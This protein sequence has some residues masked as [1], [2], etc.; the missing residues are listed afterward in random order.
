MFLPF[1]FPFNGSHQFVKNWLKINKCLFNERG[2]E[3]VKKS[4]GHKRK[5][6]E[7]ITLREQI[8]LN[9]FFCHPQNYLI[10]LNC[11]YWFDLWLGLN[12]HFFLA[13]LAS[14][15]GILVKAT[16]GR[17]KSFFLAKIN[18]VQRA[19]VKEQSF[20]LLLSVFKETSQPF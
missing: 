2:E 4:K 8:K 15:L 11:T 10:Y 9:Y 3:N 17:W 14:F 1:L 19:A 18:K 12:D 5:I 7:W 6:N 20:S 16:F 13:Q